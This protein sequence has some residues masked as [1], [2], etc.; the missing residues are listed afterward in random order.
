MALIMIRKASVVD[1][2]TIT[3]PLGA[4]HEEHVLHG[5]AHPL[6]TLTRPCLVLLDVEVPE[7]L[8]GTVTVG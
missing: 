3:L 6:L 8:L 5:G 2:L 4:R 7:Y 1:S